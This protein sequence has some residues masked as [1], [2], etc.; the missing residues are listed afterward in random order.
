MNKLLIIINVALFGIVFVFLYKLYVKFNSL[1]S[2]YMTTTTLDQT[3]Q[4][5]LDNL[6]NNL[7]SLQK[8]QD[9]ISISQ[10]I[11][12][13]IG[14]IMASAS[15]TVP[16]G[17]L[18]CDGSSYLISDYLNLFVAIGS[19]YNNSSNTDPNLYFSVPD[20]RGQFIR[21]Q[22]S[23]HALGSR[24]TYKT[25][26]PKTSPFITDSQGDHIHSLSSSGAHTHTTKFTL[27]YVD[28]T[29]LQALAPSTINKGSATYSTDS[30]GNHTHTI[31]S[32][33]SHTH[34]IINGGDSETAPNNVSLSY[35]IRAI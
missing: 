33:G 12:F 24:E 18:V 30:Q 25:A 32:N 11:G 16:Q 23:L 17:Y 31:S 26:L 2:S 9:S 14:S 19:T 20:L 6:N 1:Y 27:T 28:G 22:D 13:P 35:L 29:V 8:E 10:H 7:S 4:K 21:G 15:S 5:S 34:T 3:Q